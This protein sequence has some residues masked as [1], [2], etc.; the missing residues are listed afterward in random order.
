MVWSRDVTSRTLSEQVSIRLLTEA[1]VM[2]M[3]AI[4]S[5]VQ[6]VPWTEG[7]LRDSVVSDRVWGL[8]QADVLI[9]YSVMILVVDEA[10]L[11]NMSIAKNYQ[12]QGWGRVLLDFVLNDALAAGATAVFL[13]VRESNRIALQLY[14]V[15]GFAPFGLRKGYYAAQPEREAAVLMR[16]VFKGV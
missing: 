12:T 6:Q 5:I 4:E 14:R 2:A 11:L 13:E 8:F 9:G 7:Q 16:K 1:H 10:Q 3:S 15:M